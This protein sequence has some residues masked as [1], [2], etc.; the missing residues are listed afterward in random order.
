MGRHVAITPLPPQIR[1]GV[2]Q[3]ATALARAAARDDHSQT[4]SSEEK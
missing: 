3:L 2:I 4:E 1:D